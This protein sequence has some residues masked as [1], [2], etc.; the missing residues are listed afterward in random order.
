MTKH[1][2]EFFAAPK[3]ILAQTRMGFPIA[4]IK[5]KLKR[6]LLATMSSG[7][8]NW[9]ERQENCLL[10]MKAN[11]TGKAKYFL[12]NLLSQGEVAQQTIQ[13]EAEG[14]EHSLATNRRAKSELRVTSRKSVLDKRW[15][16]KLP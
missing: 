11:S 15:H 12:I 1:L 13:D 9:K 16:W 3:A 2:K 10:I 14:A 7:A 8:H 4:W 6:T 5:K